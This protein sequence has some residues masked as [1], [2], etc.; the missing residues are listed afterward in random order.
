MSIVKLN[1]RSVKD[2]T[3]FGSISSLGSLTHIATQTASSS[4]SISFTSGIDSTYKE[5]IFY[6]KDIHPAT[7]GAFFTFQ[8]DTG[9]NT[10]YNQ[11]ITSTVFQARH[12]EGDSDTS[13]AYNTGNDLAQSTSFHKLSNTIG[14]DNDQSMSGFCHIF[15]PSSSTFVKHFI[16]NIQH[17]QDAN[18]SFNVYTA[19]YFNT[20]TAITRFQFKMSSGNIDS[21]QILL[22]GLN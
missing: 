20:T 6:F 15:N 10:N 3:A 22:F 16:S 5:Y 18:F 2:I 13:L 11:T 14:N 8:S 21:G 9:T 17:S 7:D 1:N 4:A 19:G 12:D